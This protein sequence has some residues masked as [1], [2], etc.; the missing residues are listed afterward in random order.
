MILLKHNFHR[1]WQILYGNDTTNMPHFVV[2]WAVFLNINNSTWSVT[3]NPI[4]GEKLAWGESFVTWDEIWF[5]FKL[6]NF[7]GWIWKLD[8][9]TWTAFTLNLVCHICRGKLSKLLIVWCNWLVPDTKIINHAMELHIMTVCFWHIW[10][11]EYS[12]ERFWEVW[13]NWR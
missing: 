12:M 13:Y 5:V 7:N 9:P 3:Y 10:L 1:W 6:S 2:L 8:N 11:I 4:W